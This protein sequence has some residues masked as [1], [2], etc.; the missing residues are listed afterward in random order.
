MELSMR[1]SCFSMYFH[2]AC[3]SV[4]STCSLTYARLQLHSY[5]HIHTYIQ[6]HTHMHARTRS[7]HHR[8]L[9][10]CSLTHLHHTCMRS[11]VVLS[12]EATTAYMKRCIKD[13]TVELWPEAGHLDFGWTHARSV[14]LYPRL[15]RLILSS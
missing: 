2:G 7:V 9:R 6:I 8:W 5:M 14:D 12:S 10:T 15:I 13:L 11:G 3:C 4:S 1:E